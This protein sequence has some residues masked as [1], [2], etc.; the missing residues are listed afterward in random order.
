MGAWVLD[1]VSNWGGEWADLTHA[2]MKFRGPALSGDV[3]YLDG[4]VAEVSYDRASGRPLAFVKVTMTNQLGNVL[5]AGDV[6]VLMPSE[7]MPE[8]DAR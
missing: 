2:N 1:Y 3:S 6:E 7:S 5:A 4:E 8:P